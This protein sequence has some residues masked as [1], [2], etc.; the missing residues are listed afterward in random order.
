M[1]E[2]IHR[3]GWAFEE[4]TEKRGSKRQES[5]GGGRV[6]AEKAKRRQGAAG[7]RGEDF[8]RKKGGGGDTQGTKQGKGTRFHRRGRKGFKN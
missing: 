2:M 6:W 4:A 1:G 3:K 7:E 8:P 5:L